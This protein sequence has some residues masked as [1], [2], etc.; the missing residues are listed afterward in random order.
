MHNLLTWFPKLF[1][2]LIIFS[3]STNASLLDTPS[4]HWTQLGDSGTWVIRAKNDSVGVEFESYH[5]LAVSRVGEHI[6]LGELFYPSFSE[7]YPA[8]PG[9]LAS[10]NRSM[11]DAEVQVETHCVADALAATDLISPKEAEEAIK[12][13]LNGREVVFN[14][15]VYSSNGFDNVAK[16]LFSSPTELTHWHEYQNMSYAYT[17]QNGFRLLAGIGFN[18]NN[19]KDILFTAVGDDTVCS[20]EHSGSIMVFLFNSQPIQV[21]YECS[22]NEGVRYLNFSPHTYDGFDFV[23]KA[24]TKASGSVRVE[25]DSRLPNSHWK[26]EI[27]A[28]GFTKH[29]NSTRKAL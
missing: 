27:S 1:L 2:L 16:H 28:I 24:L 10:G 9:V 17:D 13:L 7:C 12:P 21:K 19:D 5:I 20:T 3:S 23:I 29:W 6:A 18:D 11:N 14:S 22:N 25:S 15:W 26:S 8:R 4:T